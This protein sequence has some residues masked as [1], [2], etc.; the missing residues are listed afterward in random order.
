[1][2]FIVSTP[3]GNLSDI[4]ERALE[5]LRS[6]DAILCED[7]RHSL[8]LLDHYG[9]RKKLISY[10]KFKEKEALDEILGLLSEGKNLALIS[11]AGT[12]CINDPG[13]ILVNACLE[14]GI[15]VSAIPGP[16]SVVQA[17][18]MS[19]FDTSRFQFVGFLPKNPEKMIRELSGFPGTSAAFESPERLCDTLAMIDGER[20]IA[21]VREMTKT[22]EECKRGKAKDVLAYYRQH[23]PKGEIVL[24]IREGKMPDDI[25]SEELVSLLMEY[26]GMGMKEAIKQAAKMK[27]IGKREVY[28]K[29]HQE[30]DHHS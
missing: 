30:N 25:S 13:Q 11:D 7:T 19:G 16:C 1:M 24:L 28:K 22:F 15:A 18:V 10:H 20:E 27:G 6:V 3:I 5:T 14:K 12:P 26:L 17:L 4:S 9:I 2:L 23:P 29:M 21:V 8:R